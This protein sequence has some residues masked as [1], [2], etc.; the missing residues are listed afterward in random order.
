MDRVTLPNLHESNFSQYLSI[1]SSHPAN[2]LRVFETE[3]WSG[4]DPENLERRGR[5]PQPSPPP[6]SPLLE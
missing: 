1:Q 4:A 2:R 3:G 5:V 6:P